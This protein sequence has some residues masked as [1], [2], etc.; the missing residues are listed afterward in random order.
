MK[1]HH[2][3][4]KKPQILAIQENCPLEIKRK[5]RTFS[6]CSEPVSNKF[7]S[8]WTVK[9]SCYMEGKLCEDKNLGVYENSES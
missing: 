2:S 4:Q 1:W 5:T 3:V 6:K 9:Q 7:S 8:V